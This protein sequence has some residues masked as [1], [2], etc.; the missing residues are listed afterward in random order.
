[1]LFLVLLFIGSA[2][3]VEGVTEVILKSKLFEP[4]VNTLKERNNFF[5]QL[6]SCGFCF[7]MWP[8]MLIS[9]ILILY[10]GGDLILYFPKFV[11]FSVVIQR[12]SNYIHNFNDKYLD[13]FY[14]NK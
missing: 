14:Q 11:F 6:L 4:L 2:V 10:L 8:S 5:L 12:L 13:K 9:L 1:M 7:S 3:F